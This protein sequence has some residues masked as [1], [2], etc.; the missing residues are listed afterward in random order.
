M[1]SAQ[2]AEWLRHSIS[3]ISRNLRHTLCNG[4]KRGLG[5][6]ALRWEQILG[7][8]CGDLEEYQWAALLPCKTAVLLWEYNGNKFK[9]VLQPS[10]PRHREDVNIFRLIKNHQVIFPAILGVE[11]TFATFPVFRNIWCYSQQCGNIIFRVS[12]CLSRKFSQF[13]CNFVHSA[14]FTFKVRAQCET[15][16]RLVVQDSMKTSGH[17]RL[18]CTLSIGHALHPGV[19]R[20]QSA[21]QSW[22]FKDLTHHCSLHGLATRSTSDVV[23]GLI[24]ILVSQCY[25][26]FAIFTIFAISVSRCFAMFC[27]SCFASFANT[28]FTRFHKHFF[29]SFTFVLQD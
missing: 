5:Y 12:S 20:V 3:V 9:I 1:L 16:E 13:V 4:G 25:S 26:I 6:A 27:K 18:Y 14:F 17:S 8:Q 29:C 24:W 11:N 2:I 15:L 23:T 22:P 10:L 21:Q 7:G 28:S 19:Q